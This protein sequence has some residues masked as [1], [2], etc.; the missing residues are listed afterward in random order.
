MTYLLIAALGWLIFAFKVR[1]D[2]L[3]AHKRYRITKRGD[4]WTVRDSR[5]RFV[6]LTD[7]YWNICRLGA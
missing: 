6:T 2:Y 3:K 5:G 1:R 7:N 4:I